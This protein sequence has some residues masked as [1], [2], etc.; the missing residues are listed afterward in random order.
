MVF[1]IG[2]EILIHQEVFLCSVLKRSRR[3]S[4]WTGDLTWRFSVWT[5]AKMLFVNGASLSYTHTP[6]L[7]Q[8]LRGPRWPRWI[9]C[10]L[11]LTTVNSPTRADEAHNPAHPQPKTCFLVCVCVCVS[12]FQH[13]V[14][15]RACF[16]GHRSQIDDDFWLSKQKLIATLKRTCLSRLRCL[17]FLNHLLSSVQWDN[18][19][20]IPLLCRII[21]SHFDGCVS[22]ILRFFQK[23]ITAIFQTLGVVSH[24]GTGVAES[25]YMW[26]RV[27]ALLLL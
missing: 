21:S 3:V 13:T 14:W 18:N 10:L 17:L 22:F 12:V 20:K 16:E 5:R 26:A 6:T 25:L 23:L 9:C 15:T 4:S 19:K 7:T 11:S 8:T 1:S 24:S 2:A 27:P